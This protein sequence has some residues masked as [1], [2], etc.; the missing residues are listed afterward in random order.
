MSVRPTV[1]LC[2]PALLALSGCP[3][4]GADDRDQSPSAVPATSTEVAATAASTTAVAEPRGDAARGAKLVTEMECHRCHDG[5]ADTKPIADEQHCTHCHQNVMDGRF[6]QKPDNERWQKNVAH[7]TQVPTLASAGRRFRYDWLVGFIERPHDVRPNLEYSMPRLAVTREQARDIATFLMGQPSERPAAAPPSGD[8]AAGRK[9]IE[10]KA[11]GTCHRMSGVAALPGATEPTSGSKE[12]R[13][14]VL[15][16]PDL[17]FARDRLAPEHVVQWLLDPQKIKPGTLMP[18]TPMS[19]IE[20]NQIAAYILGSE[21]GPEP[22]A[23]IPPLPQPLDRRVAWTEVNER[24][25]AKI[26]RHC[27][28]DPDQ[29]VGDG[30]PGNTGGFGFKPRGLNLTRY[31]YVQAGYRDDAGERRSVF[32]KDERG[33]PRLVAALMARHAEEAGKPDPNVRGMPLGLPPTSIDDIRLVV[34]WVA[35][36][37]PR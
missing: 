21:L 2:L 8:A 17:R 10:D 30:G 9:L 13:A 24:V 18:Q 34:T 28:G 35:Q 3:D 29:A 4:E 37:R 7:L 23:E 14:A 16:A 6:A 5:I 33:V 20:A 15:L 12:T 19:E 22:V 1:L 26:C 36:G 25:F 31:E 32:E 11:C 27:H